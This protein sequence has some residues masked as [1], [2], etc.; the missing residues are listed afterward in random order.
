MASVEISNTGYLVLTLEEAP[1]IGRRYADNYRDGFSLSETRPFCAG[2]G[3]F[4]AKSDIS[5]FCEDS[6]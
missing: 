3:P 2:G 6:T 5:F 1:P 4:Q